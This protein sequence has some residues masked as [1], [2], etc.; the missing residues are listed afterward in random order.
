MA[1]WVLADPESTLHFRLENSQVRGTF[2]EGV[3]RTEIP[4]TKLRFRT[5]IRLCRIYL[6]DLEAQVLEHFAGDGNSKVRYSGDGAARPAVDSSLRGP[7]GISVT[8]RVGANP[9]KSSKQLQSAF[10]SVPS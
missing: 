10:L 7:R 5:F 2:P 4:L 6:F 3:F 9:Y 8:T 1:V